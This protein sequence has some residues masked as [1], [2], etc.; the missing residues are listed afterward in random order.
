MKTTMFRHRH[1]CAAGSQRGFT[2][3]E[4]MIAITISMLLVLALLTLLT[5]VN[6]NNTELTRT[7]SIIENGR[8]SLQL[9]DADISHSGF[10]GG[11]VPNYDDLAATAA[12]GS[13][14]DALTV[15]FPTAVPDPC[16]A[17]NAANWTTAYKA[18]L[19][20]LPVQVYSIPSSGASP[21]CA[22]LMTSGGAWVAQPG[23][24]I[25]VV[26]HAA[27]CVASATAS[28]ADCQDTAGNLFFQASRCGSDTATYVLSDVA[29]DFSLKKG[30]CTTA[31]D[32]YRFVSTIYWVRKYFIDPNDGIPTLVRSKF[33]SAGGVLAHAG[34]ETLIEGVQGFRVQLGID[35]LTKPLTSGVTGSTLTSSSFTFAV[36]WA[37]T[38]QYYTP[39]NRGDGN[40]DTF[41]TCSDASAPCSDVFNLANAVAVKIDVLMRASSKTP[42]FT[43]GRTYTVGGSTMGPYSDGYKRHVF[44]QTIRLNNVS[45]RREVPPP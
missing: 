7:N 23:T 20:A 35:N 5:N 30:N 8:F 36:S 12:P 21:V 1:G 22:S 11:F 2:L 27:P 42:S 24:D 3:I 18:Q 16:A 31:S 41:V 45:M 19:I 37:S 40:A 43:D 32:I 17:Y 4:L 14:S 39:T 29:A 44:G 15:A 9:L 25:L 6:R 13:V 28:D 26:R 10:W 34:T 33:Q 38:T